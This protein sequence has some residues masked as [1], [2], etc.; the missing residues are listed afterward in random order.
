[1]AFS[2][3]T[4]DTFLSSIAGFLRSRDAAQLQSYILVEPPFPDIYSTLTAELRNAY[5][6]KRAE[7]LAKKCNDLL[8]EDLDRRPDDEVGTSWPAFVSFMEEYLGYLCDVNVDNLL[9]THQLLSSL[10]K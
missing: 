7:A 4:V 5:P 3:P 10:C 2:T 9:E 1:M 6:K 8:P